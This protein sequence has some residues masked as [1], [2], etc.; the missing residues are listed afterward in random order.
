LRNSVEN[1][2]FAALSALRHREGYSYNRSD[3]YLHPS[4]WLGWIAGDPARFRQFEWR[5]ASS[6]ALLDVAVSG[7]TQFSR[8][9]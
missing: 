8:S 9:S 7:G 6:R 3:K 2:G 1:F 5:N 4:V